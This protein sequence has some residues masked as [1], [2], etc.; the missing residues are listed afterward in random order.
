MVTLKQIEEKYNFTFPEYFKRLWNDGMLNYMRGFDQGLK[1][2]ETWVKTV[3]P[4][5][6]ENP[7][8]LLHSGEAQLALLTPEAILNFQTPEFWDVERHHFI[9]FAKTL[10]GN[11]YAFY[12]NVKVEGEAP[13]V[14]IWDE[15]DDTEYYAKNFEDFIFRQMLESAEDIDKDDL[16]AEYDGD[17]TAYIE[18]VEKDIKSITP[19]LKAEYIELLK[20]IYS[21]EPKEGTLAYSL[22]SMSEAEE[23]VEEY[24]DFE[25]LGESFSHEI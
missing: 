18:D 14:E 13:I 11:Y 17:V 16:K 4:T 19:Y 15:M 24:L 22:I 7:P 5:L 9:P 6:Q 1:E 12:D 2:G 3:Y 10:E 8:A 23:I 20:E 21:R 25:L